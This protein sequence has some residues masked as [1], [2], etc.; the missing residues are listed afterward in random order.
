MKF[1][2]MVLGKYIGGPYDSYDEAE[3]AM[4]NDPDYRGHSCIFQDK[5]HICT[6]DEDTTVNLLF[7]KKDNNA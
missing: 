4:K 5:V 7:S 2:L 1:Y 3:E 6:E